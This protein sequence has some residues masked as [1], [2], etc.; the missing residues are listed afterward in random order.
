MWIKAAQGGNTAP[1]PGHPNCS[2][3]Q[4]T[5]PWTS[6]RFSPGFSTQ[7]SDTS[8]DYEW[9]SHLE[10]SFWGWC[11]SHGDIFQEWGVKLM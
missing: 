4:S 8:Q 11:C 9:K 7:D 1:S 5:Q 2:I 10:S 3:P 6:L